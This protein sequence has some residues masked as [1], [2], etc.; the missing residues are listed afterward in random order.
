AL[1]TA[2]DASAA[3]VRNVSYELGID[4]ETFT[5]NVKRGSLQISRGS[6]GDSSPAVCLLGDASTM[7]AVAFGREPIADAEHAGRLT[8]TGDRGLAK[9]F[10][11][12]FPV[13]RAER[14][15]AAS[16]S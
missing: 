11:R 8:V 16:A 1:K 10:T 14:P 5:V 2:F 6:P 7:R 12:M 15:D 13:R 4:G 9:A 3:P